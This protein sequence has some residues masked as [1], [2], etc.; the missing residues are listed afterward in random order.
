M[1]E[2]YSLTPY[3]KLI[4]GSKG[5]N[6][7]PAWEIIYYLD[8]RSRATLYDIKKDPQIVSAIIRKHTNINAVMRRLLHHNPP[9][10]RKEGE[11][12]V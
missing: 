1:I 9:I 5:N 3:G 2:I 4:A 12:E 11:R 10:V 7:D 6:G 8:F